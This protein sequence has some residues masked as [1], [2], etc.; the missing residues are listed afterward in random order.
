M[1]T[2]TYDKPKYDMCLYF[3]FVFVMIEFNSTLVP[4]S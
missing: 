4:V 1:G 2:T 3:Q